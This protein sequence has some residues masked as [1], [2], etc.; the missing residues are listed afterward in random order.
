MDKKQGTKK[1]ATFQTFQKLSR[2]P[3]PSIKLIQV[4]PEAKNPI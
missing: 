4:N 1:K 2:M 3:H